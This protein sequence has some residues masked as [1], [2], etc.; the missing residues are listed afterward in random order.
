MVIRTIM[1]TEKKII[2]GMDDSKMKTQKNSI[3]W[4]KNP[5]KSTATTT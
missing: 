2:M 4:I 5:Y 3:L 1:D